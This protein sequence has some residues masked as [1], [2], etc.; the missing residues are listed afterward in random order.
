MSQRTHE[1]QRAEQVQKC[2]GRERQQ[3]ILALSYPQQ[4]QA[5][6]RP[7]RGGPLSACRQRNRQREEADAKREARFHEQLERDVAPT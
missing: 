7:G 3:A 6:E 4:R 1:R 5:L 2:A